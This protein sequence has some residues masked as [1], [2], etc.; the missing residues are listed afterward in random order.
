MGQSI[1][2]DGVPAPRLNPIDAR[3]RLTSKHRLICKVLANGETR[4]EII[5][6]T[7]ACSQ[8][9][10]DTVRKSECARQ[11]IRYLQTGEAGPSPEEFFGLQRRFVDMSQKAADLLD[12]KL[13]HALSDIESVRIVDV[14]KLAN[15][16]FDRVP[17]FTCSSRDRNGAPGIA[18][19]PEAMEGVNRE[20]DQLRTRL[21]LLIEQSEQLPVRVGQIRDTEAREVASG[22]VGEQACVQ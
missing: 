3:G 15:A 5:R 12:R 9:T 18:M 19:T 20:A 6:D 4:D 16:I 1:P 11:Y 2:T 17:G 13:E 10:L 21:S 22:G 8:N 7:A 14:V